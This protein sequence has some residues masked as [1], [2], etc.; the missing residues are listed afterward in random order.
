MFLGLAKKLRTQ[1]PP[2]NLETETESQKA[3]VKYD[4]KD[5]DPFGRYCLPSTPPKDSEPL[6]QSMTHSIFYCYEMT[7][8]RC[9][10]SE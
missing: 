8:A 4:K 1:Q 10:T 2:D 3:C 6:F 5:E 9:N 7:F